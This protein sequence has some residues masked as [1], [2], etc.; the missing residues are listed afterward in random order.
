MA[1]I[2]MEEAY[3]FFNTCA[4]AVGFGVRQ[5]SFRYDKEKKHKVEAVCMLQRRENRK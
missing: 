3:P 2:D 4:G 5:N 1:F